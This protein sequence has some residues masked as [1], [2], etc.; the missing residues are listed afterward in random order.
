LNGRDVAWYNFSAQPGTGSNAVFAAHVTWNGPAV[1][2]HL[3][4]LVAGD[5]IKLIGT[6]GAVIRYRVTEAFLVDPNDPNSLSV[7]SG[8][9]E[10]VIT[11]I[12]CGG[13]PY[14]IGGSFGYDYTHRLVVR[15]ELVEVLDT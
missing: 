14:Y 10:D 5:E 15:A 4:A 11:L 1:F 6:N 12:T 9:S 8:S 13:S 2:Y 7:M 3:D